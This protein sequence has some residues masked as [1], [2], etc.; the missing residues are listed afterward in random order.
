MNRFFLPLRGAFTVLVVALLTL[1]LSGCDI[2]NN[3]EPEVAAMTAEDL[4]LASELMA[5]ALSD[6]SEGLMADLNDMTASVENQRIVYAGRNFWNNPSLR[7]CRGINRDYSR[8]FDPATGTFTIAYSRQH[9]AENCSKSVEVHL[10]YVFTDSTG[11]FVA[12]PIL[13]RRSIAE[14]AFEGTRTGTASH[15]FPNG[16]TRTA[17]MEQ[18]AQWNLSGLNGSAD[19]ATLAGTQTK[20]GTYAKTMGDS[21]TLEGTY[22]LN[23]ETVDVTIQASAAA[24]DDGANDEIEAKVTGT[25]HYTMTMTQTVNGESTIKET[26]GTIDLEGNGHALLR[27]LGLN[28]IY[29]INLRDGERERQNDDGNR[30]EDD[31]REGDNGGDDDEGDDNE[32][33]DNG[34]G[35]EEG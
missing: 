1:S 29:R 32:G 20:T 25:I 26:E 35:G 24:G 8:S 5:D 12:E 30:G 11:A 34:E 14:I 9:E 17:S 22:T 6:Q 2:L 3:D 15:M 21:L 33:D 13:Q 16:D 10:Q 18:E 27:F 7:P 23:M 28:P 19:V 4:E 31:D